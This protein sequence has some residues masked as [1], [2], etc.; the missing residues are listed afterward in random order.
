[1]ADA[2]SSVDFLSADGYERTFT[3]AELMRTWPQ[4]PP[5]LG[6][7]TNDLGSCG[8][9]SYRARGLDAARPL[10]PASVMLAFEQDGQ[11]LPKAAP[12]AKTGRLVGSGPVRLIAPQFVVSPPD[13][14]QTADA[15]CAARVAAAHRFHEDYDHNG[16]KNVSAVVAV[17]INPLPK[18]TRD[19]DWQTP[20]VRAL[21][22][23]EIVFFG[24]LKPGPSK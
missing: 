15:S 10:A 3:V 17:R 1:V 18:G 20:A 7:G 12:D 14:P 13:L 8:W 11:T 21:A 2:A 5:V 4:A 9:V 16:G 22:N 23:E 6:L 19:I 24:A